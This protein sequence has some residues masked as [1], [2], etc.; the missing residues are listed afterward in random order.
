[1]EEKEEGPAQ[2]PFNPPLALAQK[3]SPI[4]TTLFY[5]GNIFSFRRNIP[6]SFPS[7]FLRVSCFRQKETT[8]NSPHK[9]V[10]VNLTGEG[11]REGGEKSLAEAQ[12][13]EAQRIMQIAKPPPPPPPS[14]PPSPLPVA[15]TQR[16]ERKEKEVFQCR[17]WIQSSPLIERCVVVLTH[18]FGLYFIPLNGK[19]MSDPFTSFQC[20]IF[21]IE[22]N[23]RIER[24]QAVITPLALSPIATVIT[25]F[26]LCLLWQ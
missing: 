8:Q 19:E 26:P 3:G 25:L 18:P 21:R 12:F 16:K 11:G 6:V 7:S 17:N 5:H 4:L 20:K 10:K 9:R 15:A 2:Y 14:L 13:R 23:C 22:E 1:M 24:P